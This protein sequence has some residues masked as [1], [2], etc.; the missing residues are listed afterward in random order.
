LFWEAYQWVASNDRMWPFSFVNLCELTGMEVQATR[1]RLLG[2]M[3]PPRGEE[4]PAI[5]EIVEAA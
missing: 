5:D 4:F 3:A 2:E 1:Q